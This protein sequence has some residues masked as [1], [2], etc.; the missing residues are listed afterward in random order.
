M[1]SLR[2]FLVATLSRT[3]RGTAEPGVRRA[4]TELLA[5]AAGDERIDE[6]FGDALADVR[7]E[8]HRWIAQARERGELRDDVDADTL[9]DLVAGAA[10]YPLLWR[11][12]ALAEDRVAAVVDLLLDGAARR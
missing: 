3:A 8:G 2:E 7:A 11:G 5:A 6:A 4:A 10:Y 1:T 9:L 12:R